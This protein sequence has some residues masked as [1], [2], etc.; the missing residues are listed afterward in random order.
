MIDYEINEFGKRLGLPGLELNGSGLASL[1]LDGVGTLTIE[2][3][4]DFMKRE[5]LLTLSQPIE[6]TD[7]ARFGRL[8]A[9]VNWRRRP[10]FKLSPA[11][12]RHHLIL[13]ARFDDDGVTAA[14]LENALRVMADE[15]GRA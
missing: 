12:F 15:I 14:L 3:T 6:P 4:S 5:L 9:N 7:S 2:K 13:T 11:F 10:A 8:L 1:V